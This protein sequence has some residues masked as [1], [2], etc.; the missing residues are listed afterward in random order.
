MKDTNVRM[1]FIVSEHRW[2][3]YTLLILGFILCILAMFAFIFECEHCPSMEFLNLTI[4]YIYLPLHYL[5]IIERYK[6]SNHSKANK[7]PCY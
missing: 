1:S 5:F 6:S 4:T 7:S 3:T 2:L